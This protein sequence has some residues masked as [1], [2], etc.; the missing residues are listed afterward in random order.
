MET[1]EYNIN[2]YAHIVLYIYKGDKRYNSQLLRKIDWSRS[3]SSLLSNFK[4]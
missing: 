3:I 4:I 1:S 2:T